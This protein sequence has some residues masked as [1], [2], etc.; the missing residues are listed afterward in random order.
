MCRVSGLRW[1]VVLISLA[2]GKPER[3]PHPEKF[4]LFFA[5]ALGS[6]GE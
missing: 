6:A 1:A 5:T 4:L 2:S 3:D